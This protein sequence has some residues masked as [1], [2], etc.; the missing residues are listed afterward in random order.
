MKKK[1]YNPFKMWGSWIGLVAG[2]LAY[3]LPSWISNA[4]L[5]VC[6]PT[7]IACR[8]VE[9]VGFNIYTIVYLILGFLLVWAIQSLWRYYRK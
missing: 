6:D 7:K 1:N 2:F 9:I 3:Y 4:S 8:P 5:G